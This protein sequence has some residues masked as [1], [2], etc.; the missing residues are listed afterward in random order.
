MD[1]ALATATLQHAS[2]ET[3]EPAPLHSKIGRAS[4]NEKGQ[5]VSANTA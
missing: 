5:M 3:A 1:Y 2:P 4:A